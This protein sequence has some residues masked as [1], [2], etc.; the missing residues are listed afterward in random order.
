M[1]APPPDFSTIGALLQA[2]RM[3]PTAKWIIHRASGFNVRVVGLAQL[4]EAAITVGA[5]E[6]SPSGSDKFAAAFADA[7]KDASGLDLDALWKR[8]SAWETEPEKRLFP[9]AQAAIAQASLFATRANSEGV[10]SSRDFIRALVAPSRADLRNSVQGIWKR[11]WNI[12]PQILLPNLREAS[13]RDMQPSDDARAWASLSG[14]ATLAPAF[15]NDAAE[16]QASDP[17]RFYKDA[18]RL[19]ELACLI[20]N[21]PPMAVALFGDWGSGK[22]TFMAR[23]VKAVE[24]IAKA[25]PNLLNKNGQPVFDQHIHQ[26]RFNAWTY[27]DADV[28]AGMATEIFDQLRI[29]LTPEDQR[30]QASLPEPLRNMLHEIGLNAAGAKATDVTLQNDIAAQKADLAERRRRLDLLEQTSPQ[31]MVDEAM[32]ALRNEA[33]RL[34]AADPSIPQRLALATGIV[35]TDQVGQAEALLAEA[36]SMTGSARRFSLRA[37][38]A[39]T[40]L[41]TRQAWP[42]LL[43]IA[44][45]VVAPMV[46][47]YLLPP[48][49]KAALL[50]AS[51]TALAGALSV[52]TFLRKVGAQAE[53]LLEKLNLLDPSLQRLADARQRQIDEARH[54]VAVASSLESSIAEANARLALLEAQQSASAQVAHRLAEMA[55][56]HQPAALLR[57]FLEESAELRAIGDR[58]GLMSRLNRVFRSLSALMKKEKQKREADTRAGK[59]EDKTLPR[60]DRII[61]YVDDLDRCRPAQVVQVLEALA[62]L[63]Q[64]DLFIAVVAVDERWLN[65]A[66]RVHYGPLI[67]AE[68][69]DKAERL[70]KTANYL[71]KIFQVPFWL[72][73]MRDT[74]SDC[75]RDFVAHLVPE[76]EARPAEDNALGNESGAI[77]VNE[78]GARYVGELAHSDPYELLQPA[79]TS[80]F[81]Y[82]NRGDTVERVS[83]TEPELSALTALAPLAGG[84]PRA[85]KRFVNLYRLARSGREGTAL[86][87]FLTDVEGGAPYAA[88][89]FALAC[90]CGVSHPALDDLGK[91]LVEAA[92][93][94]DGIGDVTLGTLLD[95]SALDHPLYYRSSHSPDM[96][97][98]FAMQAGGRIRDIRLGAV[99]KV[100]R[101][102]ARFSF[103]RPA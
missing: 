12:D 51:G 67:S 103:N 49:W 46:L 48:D 53:P 58:L 52:A 84:T 5:R 61:L 74:G 69:S 65:V 29:A 95:P 11:N 27:A 3:S 98:L 66:L 47:P 60:I 21:R 15:T 24:A 31:A 59:Q 7:V 79:D 40:L 78:R 76:A 85:V 42:L 38:T 62:L 81:A 89:A 39:L 10:I 99:Y 9:A 13:L 30:S 2:Q 50:S 32:A 20:A 83:L 102:A 75:F 86:N 101:E 64:F 6:S 73:S 25:A 100:W 70:D 16:P 4:I 82:Q 93:T 90:H 34:I 35:G 8:N 97:L 77:Y 80:P 43:A 72:P 14:G 87:E 23:M 26:I 63:L 94:P 71:E 91:K 92:N 37:R 44:L 96:R 45:L 41:G 18:E 17:L 1:D 55:A 33:E 54:H 36:R 88:L 57:A 56:G 22:S 28:W 68:G 19:A